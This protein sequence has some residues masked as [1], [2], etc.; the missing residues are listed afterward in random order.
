MRV[1]KKVLM[2]LVFA[3]IVAAG[4]VVWF[5]NRIE[6]HSNVI[7]VSGN[8]EVID[9]EMSFKLPGRVDERLFDEGE[10]VRQGD[11]VARLDQSDL[12]AEVA[13]RRAEVEA[14]AAALAELEAG[15][16]PEEISAARAAVERKA[17]LLDELKHGS[18]PEEIAAAEARCDAAQADEDYLEDEFQRVERLAPKGAA[19]AEDVVRAKGGYLAAVARRK[20]AK[21]ALN[22]LK[23]GPRQEQI[24][25]ARAALA[26]AEAECE[27]IEAGPRR[28]TIEQA[29]ARLAEHRAGLD[30]AETRLGYATLVSPLSGVVLSKNIEPGEFVGPGTP[31]IT[32]GDL[33]HVWLRAYVNETDLGRVKVGQ[34]VSVYND[35]FP[36]KAYEGRVSFIA[37]QAEFTPKTVQTEK[38]RVKLVYRLKIAIDNPRMELKPGMP[39]D[40]DIV[41]EPAEAR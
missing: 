39:A 40:A 21:E 20:E 35:T 33:E 13:V 3:L 11:V 6:G 38:Q 34:R 37:P 9:V 26:E 32:I 17:S 23:Q 31:V 16:R 25:Q 22:L 10:L 28:E 5:R 18:R 8:I 14:A 41:L 12:A 4:G 2:L 24:A 7:R 29:R 27:L 30:L 19:S 36:G 1:S 15:S